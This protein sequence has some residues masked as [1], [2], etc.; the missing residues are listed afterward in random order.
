MPEE[1]WPSCFYRCY[2][3]QLSG[4]N[5][6]NNCFILA[7]NYFAFLVPYRRSRRGLLVYLRFVRLS[8]RPSV[9]HSAFSFPDFSLQWMKIFNWNLIYDYISMSCRP[10]LSFVTLDQILTELLPL[11]FIFSFPDFFCP[12]WSE[13]PEIFYM[14]FSWI[15][16]DQVW[17]SVHVTF[18]D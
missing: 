7:L 18:F 16:V 4:S 12:G 3:Q 5:I 6:I 15:V 17:V 9:C 1:V 2:S 8:V 13:V 10:S 11:M 14:A